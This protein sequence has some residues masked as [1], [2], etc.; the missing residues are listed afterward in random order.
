MITPVQGLENRSVQHLYERW[1]MKESNEMNSY[2]WRPADKSEK[3]II[4]KSRGC[5]NTK[6]RIEVVRTKYNKNT[7]TK[8]KRC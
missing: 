2:A 1:E 3:W 7:T 5:E 8:S 6:I 4:E